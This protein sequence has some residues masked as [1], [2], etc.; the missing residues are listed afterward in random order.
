MRVC[1]WDSVKLV[2][3]ITVEYATYVEPDA[4]LELE[5]VV[6]VAVAAAPELVRVTPYEYSPQH[7]YSAK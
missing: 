1:E 3:E 4:V 2:S 6:D 5:G 7:V